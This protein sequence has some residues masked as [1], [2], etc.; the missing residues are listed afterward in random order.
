MYE[1][2]GEDCSSYIVE[3]EWRIPH[4]E[5]MLYDNAQLVSLYAKAYQK[6]K[7]ALYKNV[8]E[9]TLDFIL[10]EMTSS[11]GAFYASI[12]ADSK[13]RNGNLEEGAYYVWKK[14][15]LKAIL[16]DDFTLFSTYFS[17]TKKGFWE[18]E[19]YIL[20][21]VTPKNKIALSENISVPQL[22]QKIN[23]WKKTLLQVR[24]KRSRP[25]TD[26]KVLT[27]WNAMMLKGFIDAYRAFDKK[28]YLNTA[29]KNAEFIVKN[30]FKKDGGL[31]RNY[32][33][34]KSTINAYAE[35]YAAV[36]DAFI[37]LYEVTFEEKWLQTAKE[38]TE[39]AMKYF[40]D[41]NS[42]MF[43]FTSVEDAD[44][45]SKKTAIIDGV[46]PSSNSQMARNL[47][48]LS[49][50]FSDKKMN[51]VAIQMLNNT[52]NNLVTSPSNFT[53]WLQLL[54]SY[55]LPYYEVAIA[56][57][58]VSKIGKELRNLYIPNIIIGGTSNA[59]SEIPL[60]KN[61]YVSSQTFIYVC[62][63][64]TCKLPKRKLS[65]ALALISSID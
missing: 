56:G 30:Q 53:N 34:N 10:Q 33:D 40:Y 37:A 46:L 31:Y 3:E 48:K 21:R 11:N 39:Y 62:T 61:K 38:L 19:K 14:E 44:L 27:S 23:N 9:E 16:Q 47:H 20:Q 43:N 65:D 15:E 55:T 22:E 29:I 41:E 26:K 13:D 64:G 60:L 6:E 17:V 36:I 58:N 42:K 18:D 12:D 59:S 1:H 7:K 25:A 5:K 57:E 32:K 54:T 52:V 50:Y 24:G 28:V 2:I 51:E 4:F 35:D 63:N 49:L 45:I 8:V